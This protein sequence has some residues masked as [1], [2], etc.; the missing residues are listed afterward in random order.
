MLGISALDGRAHG[1][2][3]GGVNQPDVLSSTSFYMVNVI[4]KGFYC[5]LC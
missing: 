5:V 3:R 2:H 1:D 4:I